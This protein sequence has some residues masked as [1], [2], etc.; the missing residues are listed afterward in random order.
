[1]EKYLISFPQHKS[2]LNSRQFGFRQGLSTF[3]AL[4]TFTEDIYKAFD[5]QQFLLSIYVD[6][7]KAFDTVKHEILLQKLNFYGIRGILNDWFKDCLSNRSQSTKFL[8]HTSS[9]KHIT[10]GIPQ[11]S[12]LGPILFLLCINDLPHIFT[13]L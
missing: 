13:E 3:N 11:G 2:I 7:S 8:N 10:Y 4:S 12:V 9:I 1:M 5:S 6:F